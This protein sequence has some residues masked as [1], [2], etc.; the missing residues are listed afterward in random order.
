MFAL[1]P[2]GSRK[3]ERSIVNAAITHGEKDQVCCTRAAALLG[4]LVPPTV[5][6]PSWAAGGGPGTWILVAPR[7]ARHFA[8]LRSEDHFQSF[9]EAIGDHPRAICTARDHGRDLL[10][11][12]E[13]RAFPRP[14]REHPRLRGVHARPRRAGADLEHRGGA[15]QG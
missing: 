12:G 13:R 11:A 10:A 4:T 7:C 14:G 3:R 5:S 8:C 6:T 9:P 2:G 1:S 15:H